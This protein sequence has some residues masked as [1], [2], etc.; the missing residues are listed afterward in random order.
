MESISPPTGMGMFSKV[1][2]KYNLNKKTSKKRLEDSPQ[3]NI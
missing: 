3:K 2:K 1:L